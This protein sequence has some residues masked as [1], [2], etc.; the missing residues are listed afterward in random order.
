MFLLG[1]LIVGKSISV[2]ATVFFIS[3]L[4]CRMNG[5]FLSMKDDANLFSDP[6]DRESYPLFPPHVYCI[7]YRSK[8]KL[9][10]CE[11][12]D[13]FRLGNDTVRHLDMSIRAS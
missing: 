13:V 12:P 4:A 11:F 6:A 2:L 7:C 3:F 8:C 9:T 5:G 1:A 10:I